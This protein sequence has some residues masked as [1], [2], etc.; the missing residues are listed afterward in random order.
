MT[1]EQRR[2]LNLLIA[3]PQGSVLHLCWKTVAHEHQAASTATGFLVLRKRR[4]PYALTCVPVASRERIFYRINSN[5][6]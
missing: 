6:T 5:S 4:K 1:V 2:L 3:L